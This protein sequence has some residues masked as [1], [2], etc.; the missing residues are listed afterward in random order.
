LEQRRR[1]TA[2]FQDD[3]A[4][5]HAVAIKLQHPLKAALIDA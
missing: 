1:P 3:F 4:L 5:T 2:K